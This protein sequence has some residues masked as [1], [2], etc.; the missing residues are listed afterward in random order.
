MVSLSSSLRRLGAAA[1]VLLG[2]VAGC[3]GVDS[4]GT[5][6]PTTFASGAITGFG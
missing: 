5:G 2:V 4:G 3:G 1:L 6:A